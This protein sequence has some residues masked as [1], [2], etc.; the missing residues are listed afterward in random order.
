MLR[1][2]LILALSICSLAAPTR[3]EVQYSNAGPITVDET[4]HGSNLSGLSLSRGST[5]S[6][7]LYFTFV[8]EPI[9]DSGDE[10]YLAGFELYEGATT[11]RLGVGNSLASLAY[12][13]FLTDTGDVDLN[14]PTP[15]PSQTWQL[16]RDTDVKTIVFR[17]Q[18]VSGGAD[19][20]TLW[21]DPDPSLPE[22]AQPASRT[23]TFSADATFDQIHLREQGGAAGW[24]FRAIRVATTAAET[25][26]FD[27]ADTAIADDFADGDDS[28]PPWSHFAPT[29]GASFV[30][31]SQTYGLSVPATSNPADPARAASLRQACG[32]EF[33]DVIVAADLVA[34][35]AVAGHHYGVRA[36]STA[37]SALTQDGY[38]LTVSPSELSL[39]KHVNQLP[40]ALVSVPLVLSAS[41]DYRLVLQATGTGPV[42]LTGRVYVT[43]DLTTPLATVT[44]S[45]STPPVYR[46]GYSGV[47][48]ADRSVASDQALSASFDRFFASN[49]AFDTDVDGLADGM[50]LKVG[51]DPNDPD[52]DDD[53]LLDG[54]ELGTGAFGAQQVITTLADRAESVF[55]A[56]LDGDGDADVLS[57][58]YLDDE[59]AWYE[60]SD[61]QGTFGPQQLISTIADGAW[62]VFAADL[63][64]DGDIDVLSAAFEGD[65]VVW[66]ENTDGQGTFGPQQVITTLADGARSVLAAD[67][68][69]DGDTDVLSASSNDNKVAWYENTDG[70]GSFGPQLVIST[71]A[72]HAYSVTAAD[73]DGDSDVDVLS[74]SFEDDKIAWYENTDGQGSFGPQQL[75]TTLADAAVSVFAADLDADGDMDVLSA[76]AAQN[77]IAWYENT[78][79]QGSFGPQQVIMTLA[80]YP[81]FATDLDGDG[82]TDALSAY[83]NIAWYENTNGQGSF[84][85]Q[86]VISTLVVAAQSV[87]AAD[88]DGD[89]D[90]DVL[91]ASYE[92]DK[93]AWYEQSNVADPL[94]PDSDDDGLRD[95]FE[96][97]NG[98]DPLLAGEQGLDPDAD[99]LSNLQ[100]QTAGTDPL[101]ADSDDDGLLDGFEVTN[102]SDP[103]DT[104]S[105]DDGLLDGFEVTNGLDPADPDS[106]DDGLLDGFELT[107]GFD[108]L[109]ADEDADNRIDGQD[110]FDSDGLGNA[111]EALAGTDPNDPDSDDD[112]LLDGAELG[113]GAFG[114]QQ[115]ITTLADAALSVFAADLDGDGDA[116]ALSA[117]YNDDEIAWY[118]NVDGQ[119]SFGPQ[120][121]I[122]TLADGAQ[123]VFAADVDGDGDLDVLSAA[124]EGD[125]VAWYE[126]TDGQGSFGPEQVITALADGAQS[127]FA[128]DLD[129][130]GDTDVLSASGYDNKVAWY[131]NTDGQGSFG[132]QLVISTLASY[133]Y[134]VTAADVDGD[135]DLDVLAASFDDDTLAWYENTDGQGSFG[136]AQVIS[137]LADGP[138]S[139]TAADLDG[140]G[141]TDV[142]SASYLD[143]TL[144]WYE[145][146][147]GQG[148]F[149]PQ[150][151]ISTLAALAR[152][153]FAADVDGD[154]DTDVV[155]ASAADDEIAWYEN[156]DGQGSFGPQQL[157]STLANSAQSVF[158]ADVDGDGDTDV[159]SASSEDDK[160]AWYEQSN[161]ANPLDPDS[162][163]DGLLDGFEVT[164]GF[165]P[166]LAGEQGLDPDADGLT[167]LQEQIAGT[168]PFDTDSDADG[169]LDG[170]EVASGFDPLDSDQDSDNLVDGQDDFDA[171]GLGNAAE[172]LA[173]TDP[174]D[175]DSDNDGLL[176]GAEL[177]TGLFGAQQVI[178]TLADAAQSVVA[179]DLDGDG[180]TD[181]LSAS[182]IDTKLA[183]YEN[184]AGQGSFGPQQVISS[185]ASSRSIFAADLDGDGDTDTS[186]GTAW[187]ENT[188]GQGTFGPQ[189]GFPMNS[190]PE[191]VFAADLDGDGDTDVLA[192][193]LY[194]NT[195]AWYEN[196]DGQ[197]AFG[198]E[199]VISTTVFLATSVFAA[200]VD[201]DGDTDVLSASS[202]NDFGDRIAWYEN[203][204]GKGSF[205]PQQLISTLAGALSVF[206]ADLDGDGDTDVLSASPVDSK[207]AW[208]ENTDGQGSFSPQQ[209]ISTLAPNAR[210][211]VAADVD[212]D[213]DTDVLSAS[214]NDDKI[215][216]YENT[217]GQGNF[218]PQQV[219]STLANGAQSV[220]AADVDGDGDTDVLSATPG[221]DK[222]AR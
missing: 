108:P 24:T 156:T 66:H 75:I 194:E 102:G 193:F 53:G 4:G 26:A 73:V 59:I 195:I 168:D 150:Q 139:V 35:D 81:V 164:N 89:G 57:A 124:F 132:P 8:V 162:D 22:C 157:I 25:G 91:S 197:G 46:S 172:V 80:G 135:G 88:V 200:D 171:D 45:D 18:Y 175:P 136:S 213:G 50:E 217:D 222:I 133:A 122:T 182:A 30:V 181:V 27:F 61:G 155:S 178:S 44:Y 146:T 64:G 55:A 63:D 140:D 128:A 101:D 119:G 39:S 92:D 149:G 185:L 165:D 2:W 161:V 74:A 95:G 1:R 216:W 143:N 111:A 190:N 125:R 97:T 196:T 85:P 60:N 19:L 129:G 105:D 16:V 65:R 219:I 9:S 116:D 189:Q 144:A 109:D 70:Q 152:S 110:D 186:D 47:V 211:A 121:V 201:G 99:G 83:P 112:G 131:E 72:S 130:D 147:D 145:N 204:D 54:A 106:D 32:E 43:S 33:G 107:N 77:V 207:I 120:Q 170:F 199:Q 84:G 148:S 96:V 167:N 174:L 56:D 58:S 104:D 115:V 214:Y 87:F 176:D 23:T 38:E 114:A 142:L 215:A 69:G 40:T 123:S 160:I 177:G 52:S 206:A 13:A 212:G 103:L 48:V 49:P 191:S 209:V 151:V 134:S 138:V 31:A 71:L 36:R 117:S 184:V 14:S 126:N 79:G 51:T 78:D 12:S 34:H 210:T 113:T 127:V 159:L 67:V 28:T 137:A 98:F 202:Y 183:W 166:L 218:G 76:S 173:G 192:A 220:F 15:E 21:L 94:D 37:T 17:V 205:G 179:A 3:A 221:D 118:E 153:V 187:Y 68:D 93:I 154:G 7:T 188:D 169:L 6:D 100:E 141:D 5:D 10:P 203:T 42:Q 86:Q 180:D 163:D 198:P 90:T 41:L 20:I 208:Y 29:S 11:P 82:D 62:S 158:V